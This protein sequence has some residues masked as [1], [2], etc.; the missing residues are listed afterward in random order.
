[1]WDPV[2]TIDRAARRGPP[3][4]RI[5]RVWLSVRS[6]RSDRRGTS[7]K[8]RGFVMPLDP[9][10]RDFLE[11]LA[12]AKL[13]PYE[14]Q[15]PQDARRQLALLC[16][17][18]ERTPKLAGCEERSIRGLPAEVRVRVYRPSV[19]RPLPA[20]VFFHGGGWTM[21]SIETHDAYCR[22]LAHAS[23]WVVISVDYRLA[24]EHKFPTGLQDAFAAVCWAAERADEL[25]LDARRIAV[26]GDS[27][28]GNL[29]AAVA[30]LARD[31]EGPRL[32]LQLLIYPALDCR[33]D[34]PSYKENARGYHL[35]RAAMIWAWGHYLNSPRDGESPYASPLR[36]ADLRGLPPAMII[37]TQ[38]DPLRDEG[39]AY[40]R[41]L[42]GAGV[43]V[44]CKQYPGMIH[45]FA[46]WT[47]VS[48]RSRQA[49]QDVAVALQ[50]VGEPR[51][52]AGRGAASL[53]S[54]AF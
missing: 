17:L 39:E 32:C 29:A 15:T 38:Y 51:A 33:F 1:M 7:P 9:E 24:P 49:L 31:H 45:G 40:A 21:G 4:R 54:P 35:T 19:D 43:P 20:V 52:T 28:G 2:V 8:R 47:S 36:A 23:G 26:A 13:A 5:R 53:T 37:T 27:A 25:G 18:R 14:S 3:W 41:R 30:L 11:R 6:R 50:S 42:R 10:A 12:Q 34:T 48:A 46:L 16:C 44:T 22:R